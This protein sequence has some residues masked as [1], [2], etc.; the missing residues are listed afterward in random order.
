MP[1]QLGARLC[2]SVNHN[3]KIRIE[4]AFN[5]KVTREDCGQWC[6]IRW[7][8]RD[9]IS[10]E[11]RRQRVGNA[12]EEWIIPGRDQPDHAMWFV[13]GFGACNDGNRRTVALCSKM[14]RAICEVVSSGAGDGDEFSE[15]IATS[16]A[17]FR[18]DRIEDLFAAVENQVMK[19]AKD[20]RAL[21]KRQ[22]FPTMLGF[23]SLRYRVENVAGRRDR[24]VTHNFFSCRISNFDG[25]SL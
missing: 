24:H 17:C 15:C 16:L 23:S 10:R 7:L 14:L 19:S 5:Q 2:S 21:D 12:Q 6:E 13:N 8:D 22:P 9:R 11:Q 25:R 20:L 4:T 3:G 18:L 1:D